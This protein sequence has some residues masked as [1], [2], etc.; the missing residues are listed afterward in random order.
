MICSDFRMETRGHDGTLLD[1]HNRTCLWTHLLRRLDGI[2]IIGADVVE[3]A[4]AYDHAE[5]TT[6]AA[7]T[8]MYDL[9]TLMTKSPV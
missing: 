3:V 1:G 7:A 4:P 5:L 6:I 2:N 8:V 9:I